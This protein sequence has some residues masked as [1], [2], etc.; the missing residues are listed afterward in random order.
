MN[1]DGER[2]MKEL[3]IFVDESGDFGEYDYRAPFYIISMV[4]HNRSVDI[5][6][7]L[8]KLDMFFNQINLPNHCVHAGPVI[9]QEEE[10]R[11]MTFE[12]RKKVL[13]RLMAFMRNVDLYYESF[14]VEKKH[15][16]DEVAMTGKL[17][18]DMSKF[19]REHMEYFLNFDSIKVYYDNGQV[20]VTK[21]LSAVFNSML[22]NVTFRKVLPSDYRLFQVADLICTLKLTELKMHNHSRSKSELHFFD[23]ER[24]LKKN[25][26]KPLQKMKM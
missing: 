22:D 4:F 6:E 17:S 20:E 8:Y 15:L 12:L 5:K 26:I 7:E 18:K 21:I 25:Y 14:Y 11:Y 1:I 24:T 2:Y 9:R 10:Y 23:N 13:K 19:I 3:S 16:E